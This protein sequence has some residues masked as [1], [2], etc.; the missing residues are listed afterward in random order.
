MLTDDQGE[1]IGRPPVPTPEEIDTTRRACMAVEAE[2]QALGA[3]VN[4]VMVLAA[5][6]EV[7]IAS[8]AAEG[9]EERARFD[10][11][12]AE[13]VKRDLEATL[14][15][16]QEIRSGPRLILPDAPPIPRDLLHGG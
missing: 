15:Q 14:A 9:T 8:L 6:V 12:V 7:L 1:P 5:K 13:R 11:A 3:Q 10:M 2:I 16:V 4:P